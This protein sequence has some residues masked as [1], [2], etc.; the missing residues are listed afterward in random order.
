MQEAKRQLKIAAEAIGK[1]KNIVGAQVKIA[2]LLMSEEDMHELQDLALKVGSDTAT[3]EQ[4][5]AEFG[6]IGFGSKRFAVI[7]K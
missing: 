6:R 5:L 4:D 3:V 2:R 7:K 1:V